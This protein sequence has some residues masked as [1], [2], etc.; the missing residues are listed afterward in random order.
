[1]SAR[2]ILLIAAALLL[3]IGTI[4]V[5]RSWLASQKAKP[6]VQIVEKA[7]QTEVL[8]ARKIMPA[9]TFI[10]AE[11]LRWQAW[12]DD[13]LP[14]TYLVKGKF[15]QDEL[16]GAVVRRG[17]A[18]GQPIIQSQIVKNGQRGFLAAVLRPG[19]RAYSIKINAASAIS[20]LVFPGDRVDL[21]L[22][23]KVKGG[24]AE[25]QVSETV[26]ANLRV[27]AIDQTIDDENG[28]PRIGKTATFEVTPKQAEVLAVADQL[29]RLSLSLRSL[30]KNEQELQRLVEGGD[31]YDDGPAKFGRTYTRD[32]EASLLMGFSGS[33]VS[34]VRGS[35]SKKE[36]L[37]Q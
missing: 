37:N 31:P 5:A 20:G 7:Q 15:K 9:G 13:N 36:G 14:S 10:T 28:K 11:H 34:V 17:I 26:L 35:K 12:P 4:F 18:A 19:Y 25:Q 8:V 32:A 6:P 22:S 16:Y 33:G 30:A 27:L 2:S 21:I 23:H 3:T 1:M 29:G 24:T